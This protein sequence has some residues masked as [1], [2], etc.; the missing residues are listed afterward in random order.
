MLR[1]MHHYV[2]F[3]ILEIKLPNLIYTHQIF[4]TSL[5]QPAIPSALVWIREPKCK[6]HLH[7]TAGMV[8]KGWN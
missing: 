6:T 4:S 8:G 7:V 2:N 1:N 5:E 3:P